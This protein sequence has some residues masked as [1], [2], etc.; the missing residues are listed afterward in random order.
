MH[1]DVLFEQGLTVEP[2]TASVSGGGG[3]TRARRGGPALGDLVLSV[4]PLPCGP[5]AQMFVF[6][7]MPLHGKL[8]ET[9]KQLEQGHH[10]LRI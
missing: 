7:T 9:L 1:C 3:V 2:G 5:T 4:A 10:V 8:H 6:V